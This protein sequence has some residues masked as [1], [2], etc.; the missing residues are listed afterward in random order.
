M[1]NVSKWISPKQINTLIIAFKMLLHSQKKF[2]GMLIGATF[3][4]FIVM[5]QPGIYQGISDR[6]IAQINSIKGIDLWVVGHDSNGFDSPTYFTSTDIYRVRSIPGVL[7][8]V[9][10]YRTWFYFKHLKTNQARSWELIAVDPETMTGLPK[11]LIAGARETIRHPNSVIIDGYSLQQFENDQKITLQ[12][13]DKLL[14]DK[15]NTWT[16]TGI[17]KPLRTYAYEPKA[18]ILSNHLPAAMYQ[19]SF[20]LVKVKPH[21]NIH[22]VAA[23]ITHRTQYDALTPSE[24]SKRTLTFFRVKT[25]IM[26]IFVCIAMMGFIIGLIIM[27]Q[28]FSNFT[29]THLHQFGMLKMIGLSNTMLAR[30]VIFQ[31]GLTG[32][33]GFLLGFLLSSA[34]GIIFHDTQIAFHLTG[35]IIFLGMIG[36]LL[37]VVMS[38]FLSILKVLRLDS[39]EL[40]H[41]QN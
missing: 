31:A 8:A 14:D 24:F 18:Y 3:S 38:S 1:V 9:Q 7:S 30:M 32:G 33:I 36:T 34:F 41:D 13:K 37:I 20:I 21:F 26:I 23:A 29:L 28:I 19:P 2:T 11:E 15:K 40:C 10:L 39:V 25:P 4:A 35:E 12:L 22:Q 5:Q 27:W 6:L 17:T 16:I